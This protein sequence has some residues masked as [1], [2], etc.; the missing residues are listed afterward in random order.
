MKIINPISSI[1][2]L[3][4]TLVFTPAWAQEYI[5]G[6]PAWCQEAL[7]MQFPSKPVSGTLDGVPFEFKQAI[8]TPLPRLNRYQLTIEG[9]ATSGKSAP[10]ICF[11]FLSNEVEG[12]SF[13]MPHQKKD[14]D[15]IRYSDEC[16]YKD[17]EQFNLHST[18]YSARIVF[19]KKRPDGLIPGYISFRAQSKLKKWKD[20]S[21]IGFFYAR[22]SKD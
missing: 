7:R 12:K 22:V 17:G 2:I 11:T 15:G 21:L 3:V 4:P 6:A 20:S 1:L 9:A 10:K 14:T 18:E 16:F 19:Q 5:A 13:N 8:L